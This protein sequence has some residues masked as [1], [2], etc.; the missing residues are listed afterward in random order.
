M[1]MPRDIHENGQK[2]EK[3]PYEMYILPEMRDASEAWCR[4]IPW[5]HPLFF[6]RNFFPS[7]FSPLI[8]DARTHALDY[9]YAW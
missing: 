4:V 6:I 9:A 8:T 2:R 3:K 7:F 1:Q 5:L